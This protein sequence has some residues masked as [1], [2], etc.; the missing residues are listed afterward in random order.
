M[1]VP[2]RSPHDSEKMIAL[3][4]LAGTVAHELNNIFTAVAGNLSLLDQEFSEEQSD[5]YRDILRAA[6]RGI[7]L[8]SKLQAFAGR[9]RLERRSIE[10]NG[11]VSHTLAKL[12]HTL[13]GV[14]I[15]VRLAGG[16]FIVYA[17]EQKLS[18]T[19]VELIKNARA[20]MPETGGCLTVKT[21]RIQR[22]HPHVLLSISDN[23]AGM[24]PDVMSRATEPLFTTGP[25]GIKAGW[26][27]SNCAGF[28]RQ[29]GGTMTLSSEAGRGTTVEVSLPLENS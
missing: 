1:E 5:T 8:T 20:A 10:L 2:R 3:V 13:A 21:I 24:T 12:H 14:T 15:D 18:D 9:Q 26:G 19:V 25:N 29:S 23:G 16:E 4:Q 28:V 17:D 27:L 22:G 6:Q 7:G 11:V